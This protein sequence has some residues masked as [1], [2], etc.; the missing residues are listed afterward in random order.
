VPTAVIFC[1]V[2]GLVLGRIAAGIAST[3]LSDMNHGGVIACSS[4]RQPRTLIQRWLSLLP[5]RCPC[6]TKVSWHIAAAIGLSVLFGGF[7]CLLLDPWNCQKVHEVQPGWPL[8]G[9]RLPF[10]LCLIFLLWVA[11]LTDLLD[12]VISDSVVY[13][14]LAVALVLAFATGELQMIHIWVD[15]SDPMHVQL[16]GPYLPDWMKANQHLHGLAWSA[17]GAICGAAT[18]WIVRVVASLLLGYPALG[19]GDVTIMAMI[20]AFIGWQP[21]LCVLAIAPL[22]A[23]VVGMMAR[24]LTG[25]TFVAF[26]PYLACAA[27]IVICTWRWLWVDWLELR[28]I[29]SHW[30]TVAGLVG[31]SYGVL[32]V[33]LGGLRLFRQMPARR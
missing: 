8:E 9:S 18:T 28:L 10:H 3:T 31:G 26:G 15:W 12:Y 32:I 16:H 20:G 7:A 29:F 19:F 2:V 21:A 23:M 17:A 22:T 14:G 6:G 27:V 4:C 1:S 25:T 5:L 24:V 13:F 33:L 30:P 11:T